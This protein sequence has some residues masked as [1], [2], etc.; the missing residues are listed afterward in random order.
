ML[1]SSYKIYFFLSL[2][3]FVFAREIIYSRD[4]LFSVALECSNIN[5]CIEFFF[6]GRV[7]GEGNGEDDGKDER[8]IIIR[9]S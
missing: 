3:S 9:K 5:I 6:L 4:V 8:E 7:E 2:D 1:G